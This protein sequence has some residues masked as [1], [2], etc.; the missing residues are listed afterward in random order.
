MTAVPTS[1]RQRAITWPAA[2]ATETAPNAPSARTR[3]RPPRWSLVRSISLRRDWSR[4]ASG[5]TIGNAA[6][7]STPI[8][9]ATRS[10]HATSKPATGCRSRCGSK[11]PE[12]SAPPAGRSCSRLRPSSARRSPGRS[13]T[14][15]SRASKDWPSCSP[16]PASQCPSAPATTTVRS[17]T[18]TN[19]PTMTDTTTTSHDVAGRHA[20]PHPHHE[21]SH[22]HTHCARSPRSPRSRL[23]RRERC[24]LVTMPQVAERTSSVVRQ[25][26]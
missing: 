5:R 20:H 19:T 25:R 1:E 14:T 13:S 21:L 15:R 22:D 4:V 16:R 9:L 2:T 24:R 7:T 18:I 26:F 11:V 17:V 8:K 23:T 10:R 3:N 6:P 12:T